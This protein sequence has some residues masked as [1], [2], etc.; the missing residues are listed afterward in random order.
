VQRMVLDPKLVFESI[1]G[2]L[3][4]F[5]TRRDAGSSTRS[6]SELDNFLVQVIKDFRS[7]SNGDLETIQKDLTAMELDKLFINLRVQL[8][9]GQDDYIQSF[10]LQMNSDV[11]QARIFLWIEQKF[12]LLDSRVDKKKTL[13]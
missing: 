3:K 12:K 4:D 6:V 2:V 8:Y 13:S 9:E 11:L 5:K 7:S 1:R 10:H